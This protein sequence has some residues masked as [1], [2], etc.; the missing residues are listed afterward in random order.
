MK[1]GI[2]KKGQADTIDSKSFLK[3]VLPNIKI[4]ENIFHS[5]DLLKHPSKETPVSKKPSSHNPN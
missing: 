5:N 1:K 3:C 2:N 4:N